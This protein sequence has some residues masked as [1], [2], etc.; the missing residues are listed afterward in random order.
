MVARS[1]VVL[2]VPALDDIVR[3]RLA[4]RAPAAVPSDPDDPVSRVVLLAPFVPRPG[5]TE[6]V[7]A[8]LAS[9]FGDVT[10]FPFELTGVSR[11]PDGTVY[12][13]PEPSAPFRHLAAEL[14]KRFPEL[15]ASAGVVGATVPHL[16]VTLPDDEDE[17]A[18]ARLL[19]DRLPMRVFAQEA[20]LFWS[21]A[22]ATQTLTTF[23]FGTSAA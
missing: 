3:P 14:A 23:P 10:P 12:L 5:L 17:E 15:P 6:G 11:L 2:P 9:F 1:E 19:A 8:E 21:E 7:L 16:P 20:S 4:R 22:G 13:V 18:L